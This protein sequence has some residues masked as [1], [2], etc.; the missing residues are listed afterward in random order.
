MKVTQLLI[1][2]AKYACAADKAM[3]EIIGKMPLDELNKERGSFYHSIAALACHAIGGELNFPAMFFKAA[4]AGNAK[5][6]A[7]LAPLDGLSVPDDKQPVDEAGWKALEK[8]AHSAGEA[9]VAF[10]QALTDADLEAKVKWFSGDEV[11]LYYVMQCLCMHSVHHRA[12]I[13][14]ILDEL[15]IDNNWSGMPLP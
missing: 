13:S 12:Q 6:L 5:A 9:L 11:P 14:Q 3:F 8:A 15:K 4:C 7:A 1:E 2:Q 10:A